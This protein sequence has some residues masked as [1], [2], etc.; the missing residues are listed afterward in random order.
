MGYVKETQDMLKTC[1]YRLTESRKM[2]VEV[3]DS[4]QRPLSPYDIQKYLQEKGKELNHV[5]IYRVL[6]L[7]CSL[8]LAHRVNIAGGFVRCTLG[9]QEG[10]HGHMVCRSC[11]SITEFSD[12][13]FCRRENKVAEELGFFAEQHV[14][15]FSGLCSSCN[16][17]E[18][19]GRK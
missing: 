11:G 14:I 12:K 1:G 7:L 17:L 15:E 5:T 2:V 16:N 10:C 18:K 13:A 4:V 9:G 6:D 19:G 8:N 3:L